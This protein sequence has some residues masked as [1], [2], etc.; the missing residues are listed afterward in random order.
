MWQG[1]GRRKRDARKRLSAEG[2]DT[3][4][5]F[6][7]CKARSQSRSCSKVLRVNGIWGNGDRV[8]Y[9][10]FSAAMTRTWY[11]VH[12]G[13]RRQEYQGIIGLVKLVKKIPGQ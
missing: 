10:T 12:S 3:R 9:E 2:V 13:G 11:W 1:H 5:G 4:L 6:R 7:D 8:V